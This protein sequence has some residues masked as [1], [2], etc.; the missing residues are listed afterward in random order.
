MLFPVALE[1]FSGWGGGGHLQGRRHPPTPK[2]VSLRILATLFWK[3]ERVEIFLKSKKKIRGLG[4][5]APPPRAPRLGVLYPP[6]TP[7]SN[8]Y[9]YSHDINEKMF[10]STYLTYVMYQMTPLSPTGRGKYASLW[11]EKLVAGSVQMAACRKEMSSGPPPM[12][13]K[14]GAA[15]YVR[16]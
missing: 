16:K 8:A 5:S 6:C 15:R 4:C 10:L 14:S 1:L 3:T 9:G 2:F 11:E 13:D 12:L 7:S